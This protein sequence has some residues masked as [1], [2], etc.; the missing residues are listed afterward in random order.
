MTLRS[1]ICSV[2][3]GL[4]S[5][6]ILLSPGIHGSE[7]KRTLKVL[8]YQIQINSIQFFQLLRSLRILKVHFLCTLVEL[9]IYWS[10]DA[11]ECMAAQLDLLK[12]HVLG[13]IKVALEGD[14]RDMISLF[15]VSLSLYPWP[16]KGLGMNCKI[17]ATTF[18]VISLLW[19]PRASK[20]HNYVS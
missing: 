5:P 1:G 9:G 16:I 3:I 10:V 18:D 13:L 7:P 4:T 15:Y 17:L 8:A 2:R 11:V 20:C 12:A 14:C 19:I 6:Y